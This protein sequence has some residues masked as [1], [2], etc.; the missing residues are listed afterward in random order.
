[1]AKHLNFALHMTLDTASE[2]EE[3]RAKQV[4]AFEVGLSQYRLQQTK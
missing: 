1:V 2:V 4:G 3:A